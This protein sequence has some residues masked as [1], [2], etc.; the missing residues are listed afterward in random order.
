MPAQTPTC[1]PAVGASQ[2]TDGGAPGFLPPSVFERLSAESQHKSGDLLS[3]AIGK[4]KP[5]RDLICQRCHSLRFQNKLPADSLRVQGEAQ[6]G[7]ASVLPFVRC[8]PLFV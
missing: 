7:A 3:P 2:A 6:P 1:A 8:W 5:P 4:L